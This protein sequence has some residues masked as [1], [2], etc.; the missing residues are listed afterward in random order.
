M[1]SIGKRSLSL[2]GAVYGWGDGKMGQI[3]TNAATWLVE[4]VTGGI[5]DGVGEGMV[6]MGARRPAPPR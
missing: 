5:H 4:G 6:I 1:D 2:T 3:I